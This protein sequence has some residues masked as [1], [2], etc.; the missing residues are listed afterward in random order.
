VCLRLFSLTLSAFRI[1]G[2]IILCGMAL[3]YF[4]NS[5]ALFASA[6]RIVFVLAYIIASIP[7]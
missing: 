1:A 3:I 4:R 7:A 2:G 5:S 6:S